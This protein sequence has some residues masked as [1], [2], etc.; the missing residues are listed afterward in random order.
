MILFNDFKR[1][2]SAISEEVSQAIQR[3]LQSGWY[4]LGK[5]TE[6]LEEE[7][8]KYIG[9]K[10]GVGLNSGSDALYLAVKALG[11]SSG[12][13]VITVS[14]TMISTVDS[15][16]RNGAKPV[17]VD[18]DPE[19]YLMDASK[20]EAEISRQNSGNYASASLWASSRYEANNGNR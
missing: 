11:I 10:F 1:E 6:N 4:V 15:V 2:Y 17:F 3:V 8:S 18:V 20:V 16:T 12:D 5:E 9:A 14:H 13:E 7:F 19:T